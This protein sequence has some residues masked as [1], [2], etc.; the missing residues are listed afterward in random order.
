M[1]RIE[2]AGLHDLPGAYRVCL[3][4]G[5]AG[6]D[7]TAIYRDPDLLGH[8]YVGPY[9]A[10]GSGTQM[11]VVDEAGVCGYLLSADDTVLF[12]TWAERDWWPPLRA[13]YPL[14]DDG[15]RDAEL[16]RVIHAPEPTPTR[17]TD[18]YPAHLH[19]DLLERAR[20]RG[21]GREL[22]GG[23]L[24]ELRDRRIPGVHLSVDARN[25]NAIDFYQHLGFRE[26]AREPGGSI[27]ALRLDDGM[28]R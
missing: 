14:V 7:A 25:A 21:L 26:A 22:V 1:L 20:G 27:M 19:I 5:E 6:Q 10:Q 28:A 15:S 16:V 17:L 11:V 4:T 8:L 3:L 24:A 23:L 13:R 9:L 18:E 12:E 2:P